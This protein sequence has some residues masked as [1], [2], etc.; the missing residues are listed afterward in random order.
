MQEVVD[1]IYRCANMKYMKQ[2]FIIWVCIIM[3][4]I[5]G[6][7]C[8]PSHIADQTENASIAAQ[9]AAA[10]DACVTEAAATIQT[11]GDYEKAQAEYKV[12]AEAADKKFGL[13]P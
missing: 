9:Y 8:K 3:F 12:C 7:N 11:T 10:L 5:N 13:G 6:T 2:S 4:A 1:F